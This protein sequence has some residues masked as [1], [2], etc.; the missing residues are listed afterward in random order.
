MR[1]QR[2]ID[3]RNDGSDYKLFL[4]IQVEAVSIEFQN[5]A[6]RI[7]IGTKRLRLSLAK[8]VFTGVGL[9]EG[10]NPL[11]GNGWSFESIYHLSDWNFIVVANT[12]TIGRNHRESSDT[13]KT[14]RYFNVEFA[15][16]N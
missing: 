10:W 12:E 16:W 1:L 8:V 6:Y 2:W 5:F 11:E 4:L 9:P 3:S 15:V 7:E 14:L 13:T